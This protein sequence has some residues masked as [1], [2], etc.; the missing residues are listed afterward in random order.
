[1]ARSCLEIPALLAI[2]L[3]RSTDF[4]AVHLFRRGMSRLDAA[5]RNWHSER[6]WGLIR[7][8]SL[9]FSKPGCQNC[10]NVGM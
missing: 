1:M 5:I 6:R 7:S 3:C 9:A 10:R 2:P 4:H 8:D